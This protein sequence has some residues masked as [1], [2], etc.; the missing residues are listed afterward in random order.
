[1]PRENVQAQKMQF[2]RTTTVLITQLLRH[3]NL[4][5]SVAGDHNLRALCLHLNPLADLPTVKTIEQVNTSTGYVSKTNSSP[6]ILCG[7]TLARRETTELSE[8]MAAINLT[9]AVLTGTKT[10]QQARKAMIS[11]KLNYCSHHTPSSQKAMFDALDGQSQPVFNNI[12]GYAFHC[13]RLVYNNLM[14]MRKFYLDKEFE[15]MNEEE[16]R[17]LVRQWMFPGA[18]P[19]KRNQRLKRPITS[20]TEI[21]NPEEDEP[22]SEPLP[23]AT[24]IVTEAP[25]SEAW[26]AIE[27]FLASEN[28]SQSGEPEIN[29]TQMS[30]PSSSSS[31]PRLESEMAPKDGIA[32]YIPENVTVYTLK[33]GKKV[34]KAPKGSGSAAAVL[35]QNAGKLVTYRVATRKVVRKIR[36]EPEE[37]VEQKPEFLL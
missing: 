30:D 18:P 2:H 9:T 20:T 8:E 25:I 28:I 3:N 5:P 17:D 16:Y 29:D 15:E 23:T 13:G 22:N 26:T 1:M 36:K 11:D 19:Q 33:N 32:S 21:E 10:M 27:S 37:E 35:A 12:P 24:A 6:C 14:K 4:P 7:V 31:P 34:V